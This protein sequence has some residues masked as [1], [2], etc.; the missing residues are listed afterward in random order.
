MSIRQK[1]DDQEALRLTESV[2]HRVRRGKP[3]KEDASDSQGGPSLMLWGMWLMKTG[4][5]V[6]APTVKN[7][8][9]VQETSV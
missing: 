8:P 5:S 4:A 9:A 1:E 7:L 6:V 3:E 2:N